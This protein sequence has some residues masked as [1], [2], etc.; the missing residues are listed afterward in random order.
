LLAGA[1]PPLVWAWRDVRPRRAALYGFVAGLAFFGILLS[2]I[3]YFGFIAVLPLVAAEA[4]YIAL[5]GAIVAWLAKRG[6]RGPWILATV[7]VPIE[8]V[9]GAFP[10]GGFPWG[11]LGGAL[12]DMQ[13]GRALASWGGLIFVSFLLV[14]FNGLLVD[15]ACAITLRGRVALRVSVIGLVGVVAAS[16]LLDAT[17]VTT[18]P[19]HALKVAVLQGNDLD[20]Y[21]TPAEIDGRLISNKHFALADKLHGN[22]DLIIFPES[23]LDGDD[24]VTDA[25]LRARL[26][27]VAKAHNADVMANGITYDSKQREYNTN[28]VFAPSGRILGTYS[29][30][31]LVPFGEYVP[32]RDKLGFINE[33]KLVPVDF[34]PGNHDSV[35]PIHGVPVGQV[36]CFESV[37]ADQV[38]DVVREGAQAIVVST[39]NRSYRRS[40]ASAQH[41]A[42][43]QMRAAETGRPVV[44]A[45]IS[46]ISAVVDANG[47][48]RDPSKLFVPT[49]VSRSIMATTGETPY[50]RF[51]DW[52]VW[53]S[54]LGLLIA[55]GVVFVRR[56]ASNA[57]DEPEEP[58]DATA[59]P[60]DV[61]A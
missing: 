61:P 2:W 4:G 28:V 15:V 39:N 46:G 38:R 6:L 5:A 50:V 60:V 31:H 18:T 55:G 47:V 9:R 8:W 34:T 27:A 24:P 17:H 49:I 32:W 36:I 13:P 7:W 16:A 3:S 29:K 45:S 51:G 40:A 35:V 54:L 44:Q 12:H 42:L 22:Y 37:F 33:L 58:D 19:T 59:T 53:G 21:L 20:R 52:I 23:S 25:P 30:R 1:F 26:V 11:Q 41:L 56:R 48:V 43:S 10:L 57:P 14:V